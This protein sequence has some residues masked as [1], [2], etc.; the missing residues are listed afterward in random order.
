MY[1]IVINVP[2]NIKLQHFEHRS[3]LFYHLL[4]NLKFKNLNDFHEI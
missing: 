1:V 3:I 4:I 2:F